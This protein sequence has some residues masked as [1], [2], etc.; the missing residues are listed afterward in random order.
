MRRGG[1][2]SSLS[3]GVESTALREE[4]ALLR[5]VASQ[6]LT[7]KDIAANIRSGGERLSQPD[8][9]WARYGSSGT[10]AISQKA[11]FCDPNLFTLLQKSRKEE[12]EHRTPHVVV[13]S[14]FL[15]RTAGTFCRPN[16]VKCSEIIELDFIFHASKSSLADDDSTKDRLERRIWL[17]NEV[18][19]CNSKGVFS[20]SSNALDSFET[21][22]GEHC[23]MRLRQALEEIIQDEC[24]RLELKFA[25]NTGENQAQNTQY[26]W[27]ASPA[28]IVSRRMLLQLANAQNTTTSP[29]DETSDTKSCAEWWSSISAIER[30]VALRKIIVAG[31]VNDVTTLRESCS[32]SSTVSRSALFKSQLMAYRHFH[33]SSEVFEDIQSMC[34]NL[35]SKDEVGDMLLNVVSFWPLAQWSGRRA[36]E[37]QSHDFEDDIFSDLEVHSRSMVLELQDSIS[38]WRQEELVKSMIEIPHEHKRTKKSKKKKK[39]SKNNTSKFSESLRDKTVAPADGPCSDQSITQSSLAGEACDCANDNHLDSSNVTKAEVVTTNSTPQAEKYGADPLN[40]LTP[41]LLENN[42]SPAHEDGVDEEGIEAP[43]CPEV[44][45]ITDRKHGLDKGGTDSQD[46]RTLSNSKSAAAVPE[47]TLEFGPSPQLIPTFAHQ[48]LEEDDS[49]SED[50][51]ANSDA[52]GHTD[53][54]N[55]ECMSSPSPRPPRSPPGDSN[56][57]HRPLDLIQEMDMIVRMDHISDDIVEMAA[58]LKTVAD[59][60]RPWQGGAL[61][62]VRELTKLLW[63]AAEVHVFGSYESGIAIPPSDIDVVVSGV[64]VKSRLFLKSPSPSPLAISSPSTY[65]QGMTVGG[66]GPLPPLEA[67]ARELANQDWCA[68]VTALPSATV[69]LI[70]VQTASVPTRYGRMSVIQMD[71]TF[72][73][74]HVDPDP[75]GAQH[76]PDLDSWRRSFSE[77]PAYIPEDTS[78]TLPSRLKSPGSALRNTGAPSG[79]MGSGGLQTLQ[80]QHTGIENTRFVGRLL[81]LH[82]P[83]TP[84]ILVLK[85]LLYERGLS[86]PYKG[87]LGAFALT[88]M[89]ASVVQ[90]HALQPPTEKPSVGMLLVGFLKLYSPQNFDPRNFCVSLSPAGPLLPLAPNQFNTPRVGSAGFWQPAPPVVILDPLNPTVNIGSSCYGF[91]QVQLC[92]EDALHTILHCPLPRS[93]ETSVSADSVLG[94]MFGATHHKQVVELSASIWCP[95]ENQHRSS[96]AEDTKAPESSDD[97][98]YLKLGPGFVN[99]LTSSELTELKA[100][101]GRAQPLSIVETRRVQTLMKQTQRIERSSQDGKRLSPDPVDPAPRAIQKEEQR[102]DQCT[103]DELRQKCLDRI[104]HIKDREELLK[105]AALLFSP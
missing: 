79:G 18:L 100:L 15:N 81:A 78:P 34:G 50:E 66:S 26:L 13:H 3:N 67:L 87:G 90:Q 82:P 47:D 55:V 83:L 27:Y 28:A 96:T 92:F 2:D 70:K 17:L 64:D 37:A 45:E 102:L 62:R 88:I 14:V 21:R 85:Q 58:M 68:N 44:I 38:Q 6:V 65:R 16:D 52:E 105:F 71:I 22:W 48:L 39:G 77:P 72:V 89:C 20:L 36:S 103:N 24:W 59:R 56:S 91:K 76:P 84:L 80:R 30:E 12:L 75:S 4:K 5:H 69:P 23:A 99:P 1:A 25:A 74:G 42:S 35:A 61:A 53:S 41:A 7:S 73:F 63:P 19:V 10:T 11:T 60:R 57:Q 29:G 40:T 97:Y 32:P 43:P 54:Q 101:L 46:D 86:D 98:N 33:F 9:D 104:A 8:I 93:V 94:K 31:N 49:D 51:K 95:M